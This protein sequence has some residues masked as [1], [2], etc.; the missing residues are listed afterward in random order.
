MEKKLRQK[1][2]EAYN[3]VQMHEVKKMKKK[4]KGLK[5]KII[6]EPRQLQ[7][8]YGRGIEMPSEDEYMYEA[9]KPE[10]KKKR[11]PTERNMAIGKL[12]KEGYNMKQANEMYKK[13]HKKEKHIK[14]SDH[15]S[16]YEE[17]RKNKK[18]AG[19]LKFLL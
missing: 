12:M 1:L 14:G 10:M 16:A 2:L 4:G 18:K 5:N 15:L 3:K 7:Y 11:K 9:E 19:L 6:M 17:G 13:M 8:E